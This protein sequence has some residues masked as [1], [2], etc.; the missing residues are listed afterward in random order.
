M[1]AS[2]GRSAESFADGCVKETGNS[3][4]GRRGG[5][6]VS[7]KYFR[8]LEYLLVLTGGYGV[9]GNCFREDLATNDHERSPRNWASNEGVACLYQ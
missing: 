8:I 4:L 6:C 3:S 2:K 1:S 9:R 7:R 5:R